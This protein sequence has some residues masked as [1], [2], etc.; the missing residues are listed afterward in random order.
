MHFYSLIDKFI[1]YF[2]CKCYTLAYAEYN[3]L[4]LT[5]RF[6]I[7][8]RFFLESNPAKNSRFDNPLKQNHIKFNKFMI[9]QLPYAEV[10]IS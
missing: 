8:L 5:N 2:L 9:K 7:H 3:I 6:H 4:F 1:R 10:Q